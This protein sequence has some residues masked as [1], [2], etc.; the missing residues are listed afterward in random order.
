[1]LRYGMKRLH[2]NRM[3]C[4]E[5]LSRSGLMGDRCD[6][7]GYL[8]IPYRTND[9]NS[10][11]SSTS[12]G[13][14]MADMRQLMINLQTRER[15][16]DSALAKSQIVNDKICGMKEYQEE[17]A[18]MNE[19]WRMQG[20]KV[21]VASLQHE[22]RQILQ[23]Q[24]ENRELRQ[25]L[26]DCENTLQLVMQKHRNLITKLAKQFIPSFRIS[27]ADGEQC[28]GP[29]NERIIDL[30]R[31][32]NEC[33]ADGESISN[34]DQELI[35]RLATENACLRELL[36]IST[37]NE[38]NIAR[39]F[40]DLASSGTRNYSNGPK[41]VYDKNC[42][43]SSTSALTGNSLLHDKKDIRQNSVLNFSNG[44]GAGYHH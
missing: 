33:L 15:A 13:Q 2:S 39:S 6:V 25:A 29:I 12:I 42:E 28:K 22:N 36:N 31:L 11:M 24:Q 20:R 7:D 38:P 37:H 41:A 3:Q 40:T 1:M 5:A 19:C 23:L 34:H 17:I 27:V 9:I 30:S 32:L 44:K 16:M 43:E 18:N 10:A 35:A 14:L 21:L 8:K 26:E 4:V